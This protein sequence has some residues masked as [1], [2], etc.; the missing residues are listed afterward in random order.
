MPDMARVSGFQSAQQEEASR[1]AFIDDFMARQEFK[2]RY[3]G[4]TDPRSFV[5]ALESAAG[6][7]LANRETLIA[8]LAAGKKTRAQVL[9]AVVESN[10]VA[11]KY[12]NQAFV[13]MQYFGYL[14]RD[15]DI[16]YLDWIQTLNQTGDYRV[17]VNGFLNS[18]EYRSRFGQ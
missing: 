2:N 6:V 10:E 16:H 9:R 7:V 13:I 5:E 1:V 11:Q 3:D 8:D 12:F 17:M 4:V 14:R 18:L 15:A